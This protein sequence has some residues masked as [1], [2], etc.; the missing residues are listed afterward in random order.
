MTNDITAM[1]MIAWSAPSP[2][3]PA[4]STRRYA[5]LGL[6]R[7]VRPSKVADRAAD[8]QFSIHGN[9]KSTFTE[10]SYTELLTLPE[11]VAGHDVQSRNDSPSK[12]KS[13]WSFGR[14][15]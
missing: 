8:A 7:S 9:S 12:A 4:S 13:L 1:S 2:S 3:S 6:D 15:G 5:P 11:L 14:R 10:I